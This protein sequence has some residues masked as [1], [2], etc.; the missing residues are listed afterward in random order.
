M[1]TEYIP[2]REVAKQLNVTTRTVQRWIKTGV[3]NGAYQPVSGATTPWLV[4]VSEVERL[5]E[6]SQPKK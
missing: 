2:V 5:K 4:P 6:K 3:I 1:D